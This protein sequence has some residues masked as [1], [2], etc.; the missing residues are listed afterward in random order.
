[1]CFNT[2]E[3]TLAAR[4]N[5]ADDDPSQGVQIS[6]N[7]PPPCTDCKDMTHSTFGGKSIDSGDTP[8]TVNGYF[9][10]TAPVDL[11]KCDSKNPHYVC[12]YT[13]TIIVDLRYDF[14]PKIC[15]G[16]ECGIF[17]ICYLDKIAEKVQEIVASNLKI[18]GNNTFRY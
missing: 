18:K 4:V 5:C 15:V 6:S 13:S 11:N 7:T 17:S 14:R 12:D 9:C 8:A 1:M 2:F 3:W 16:K 10:V